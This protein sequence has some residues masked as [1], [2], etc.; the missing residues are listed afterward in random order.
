M[1]GWSLSHFLKVFWPTIEGLMWVFFI[2]TYLSSCHL[3]PPLLSKLLANIGTI[4]YSIYL[5]HFMVVLL[6]TENDILIDF[7]FSPGFSGI[8]NAILVAIPL[9]LILSTLLYHFIEK[10]FLLFRVKYHLKVE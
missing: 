8:L 6:L 10:P 4:S 5:S 9:T 1:G 3:L 7:P 2:V